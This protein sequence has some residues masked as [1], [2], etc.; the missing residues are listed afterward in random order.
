MEE[1]K[2]S[3]S[4]FFIMWGGQLVSLTGS[5]LTGFALGVWVYQTTQSAT[6]F[7]IVVLC[8]M[9]PGMLIAPLT[10]V[11]A[12]RYNRKAVMLISDFCAALCTLFIAF[13]VW[14]D[15][16][17]IWHI[18]L[19]TSLTSI[20][21]GFQRPSYQVTVTQLIPKKFFGQ[22]SGLNSLAWS[23]EFVLS[24]I[25]AG[26]LLST[27]GI[28]GIILVDFATF[29]FASASLLIIKVPKISNTGKIEKK[30][31]SIFSEIVNSLKYLR[32]KTGLLVILVI[33][34]ICNILQG[35]LVVLIEPMILCYFSPQ[36]LGFGKS[37]SAL[38]MVIS[39]VLVSIF[40]APKKLVNGLFFFAILQG[41]GM[42]LTGISTAFWSI[43]VACFIFF[44]ALPIANSCFSTLWRKKIMIEMQGR[45]FSVSHLFLRIG[46]VLGYTVGGPLAD[47]V[48]E[49]IMKGKNFI[50]TII[51]PVIGTGQGRGIGLLLIISGLVFV[52][53]G[54]FSYIN[55]KIRHL[56][57][58]LKDAF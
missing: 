41:V 2:K 6:F 19:V 36:A 44:L 38:G 3:L 51:G 17:Q 32:S 48:F 47:Y 28:K 4:Y 45:L 39:S 25:I 42:A 8:N 46:L 55:P 58:N 20:C 26:V 34:T 53:I 52:I 54:I 21:N 49:P 56:E 5:G 11:I 33:L 22:A 43:V 1:N 31:L 10:G 9:L 35:L 57:A 13:F 24:P 16:L 40:G 50:S 23:S 30:K 27:I 14:N 29:L 7:A 12:D 37:I 15:G 18:F